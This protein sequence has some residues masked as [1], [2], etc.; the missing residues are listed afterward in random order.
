MWATG[1]PMII[2]TMSIDVCSVCWFVSEGPPS[3]FC[4]VVPP[5]AASR[6]L[7][8]GGEARGRP[9][10]MGAGVGSAALRTGGLGMRSRGWERAGLLS[11]LLVVGARVCVLERR[12]WVGAGAWPWLPCWMADEVI[13]SAA[14]TFFSMRASSSARSGPARCA[15]HSGSCRRGT[16]PGFRPCARVTSW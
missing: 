12:Y 8:H 10:G 6:V 1:L 9:G 16:R 2:P 5:R 4:S 7:R 15:I 13:S 11:G 14:G 3:F